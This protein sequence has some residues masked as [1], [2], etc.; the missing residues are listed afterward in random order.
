[1]NF[2]VVIAALALVPRPQEV[3]ETGGKCPAGAPVAAVRDA[4]LPAEGYRLSV[5]PGGVSIASADDAGEFYARETLKQLADAKGAMP[6]CEISDAP[7]YPWRGLMIDDSRN[8]FGKATV[9]RYLDLMA[10]HK[11]NVFHW[12]L[13]DD[14]GWRLE[15]KR[16]PELVEWGAKRPCSVL[17][18]TKPSWPGGKIHFELD[19]Q[20]YGPFF[21][22]PDDVREILAYAKAR[23]IRVVPEIEMP[24]HVRAMLAAHPELSC[25]GPSLPR[26]PRVYWS[27]EDDVLC[28]GN[29]DGAKLMEDIL[30]E[31]CELFPDSKVIHIGGDEC[32]KT[33]WKECAK[34]QAKMKEL[35]LKD[36]RDLQARLTTR[37][38]R[39]LEAKGRRALGWD[40]ILNGDVPTSAIGMSWRTAR[41]GRDV[42]T[43]AEAARRGHDVVCTPNSYCYVD[44]A[45]GLDDDPY[46]YIGGNLPL[47]RCY[48][49]DPAAGVAEADRKHI[50]GGQGNCWSEYTTT[51]FDLDWKTWPRAC[52]LAEV[53]W[54]GPEKRDWRGFVARIAVHR[55]R[56]IANGVNAAPFDPVEVPEPKDVPELMKTFDGRPV[57]DLE[58]WEK[59]RKPEIRKVFLEK[60]YGVRPKAAEKPEVSFADD[61]PAAEM[62]DGAAVRR[63]VRISYRGPYGTNSFVVTA[64]IPK[65]ERPV[66]S[67]VLICNRSAAKNLDPTRAVKSEFWP[68]ERIVAR[69]YAAIA[70]FNGDV[71][72]ETY[73]PSTAFLSGVFPCF[74][75]PQDRNDKSWGTLSAWAWGASRV[76]DWIETEPLLDAKHVGVVG[77]S[78][79]GKTT[80]LAGATDE[81]FAMT[82]V[83]CSG[84]GGAKLAHVDLPE[85]EYYAIFL[86]SR[87]TYWFCGAFQRYCM[88]H[89][90]RIEK[91][92]AWRNDWP[93][94]AEPM[95]FDQHELA[96]LVAPRLLAIASATKDPGAGPVGEFHTARLASPAW[97]LYGRKGLGDGEFPPPQAPIVG[98]DVSYHLR[99]G[100]HDL[101]A[102]DWDVYMNFADAHGWRGK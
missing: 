85:S 75:R 64:F 73:N 93:F 17:F 80:I 48:W 20:Q 100:K 22:T 46:V 53:L 8:F 2:I 1:M 70:F 5:K 78:R 96:A 24:G 40:E 91:I 36:E 92:D 54:T 47:K 83:N 55:R 62:M 37:I 45:Q 67:F 6:C 7:R 76:M 95:D 59:V 66:P 28:A 79:G 39:F 68:A 57:A 60:M 99:E 11:M 35:G 52:A 98:G 88:N 29:E 19:D 21:Y 86:G 51:R 50:L 42:M 18:G 72:P 84:C 44:Y 3:R 15:L 102:Y 10:Q 33:R 49:F 74:E 82:C 25:V 41:H 77:H 34:C 63:R 16:H 23:H 97:E 87:V 101:T 58:T 32:P 38:A 89:D 94:V 43:A 9:K 14:Q 81:R 61:E 56:L 13:V 27:I 31:V 4:T 69:G 26:V 90:R 71:A 12:H 65:S 30:D